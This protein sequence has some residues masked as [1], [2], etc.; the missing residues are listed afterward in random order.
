MNKP[1]ENCGQTFTCV[2]YQCWCGGLGITEQQMDW[3][4]DRFEDCLCPACL[5]KVAAGELGP[6]I[7][8]T[9]QH[10]T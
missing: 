5:K 3:I 4:A 1:C 6:Q 2:G 10:T 8:Q 7:A 9:D